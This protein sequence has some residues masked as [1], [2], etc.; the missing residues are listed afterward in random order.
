MD[1]S[2][3]KKNVELALKYGILVPGVGLQRMPAGEVVATGS[4]RFK[5]RVLRYCVKGKWR[6]PD[7][8]FEVWVED[9]VVTSRTYVDPEP[10]QRRLAL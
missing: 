2:P 8:P 4:G 10:E 9:G 7:K 6:H 3:V 5:L 1:R